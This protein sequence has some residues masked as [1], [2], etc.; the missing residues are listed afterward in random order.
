MR[1]DVDAMAADGFQAWVSDVR[2]KS[3]MLD[4]AEFA[5]LA[6]PTH[7]GGTATYAEVSAG[8]FDAIVVNG[9]NGAPVPVVRH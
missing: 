4:A 6:R 7:A 8:L 1:F 5:Q 2:G 3:G 9:S